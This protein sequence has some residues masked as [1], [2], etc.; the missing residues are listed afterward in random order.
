MIREACVKFYLQPYACV[1][2]T[3]CIFT[4]VVAG[5]QELRSLL[6]WTRCMAGSEHGNYLSDCGD[7]TAEIWTLRL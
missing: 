6:G 4:F 7:R 3:V 1:C 5:Q 2:F